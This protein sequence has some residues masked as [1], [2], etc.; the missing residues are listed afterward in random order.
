MGFPL[1][2]MPGSTALMQ[3]INGDTTVAPGGGIVGS[4]LA[5]AG[6]LNDGIECCVGYQGGV[7][8]FRHNRHAYGP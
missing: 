3:V 1:A 8:A 7:L 5:Y 2:G 4:R 6:L